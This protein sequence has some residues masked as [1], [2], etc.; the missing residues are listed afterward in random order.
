[1]NK[2]EYLEKR[3]GLIN[4]AD[5]LI[6][7]G[8]IEEAN[9]KMEEV[10][11]LDNKWEE[12]AKAQANL[13]ALNDEPKHANIQNL[14]VKGVDGQIMDRID[15]NTILANDD[16][17]GSVEYRRAF[18]NHVLKGAAIPDKFLNAD[19]NT[20]TTDIGTVIPTTIME[21][22]VEKL[23]AT[24]M[25]LPLVTRTSYQGGLAIP[26]SDV[27]PVATWV[28]EGAG[29]DKQK[30]TTG[31]IVFAYHKLRCAVSIS[32]ETSVVAL[33]VF[34]TTLINN[35][36][37]AM[38]KALEQAIISGTGSGQ[39]K[40]ILAETAPAGQNID[41]AADADVDYETLINA[42]AALP[43]SYESEAVWCMTKKTFMK[44]IGMTDSN[45]QPI[46]RVS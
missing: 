28:A 42:E 18:M 8:K 39:P 10:K 22:I 17:F 1:M 33:G 23:E 32:L 38:T 44:F 6:N 24:G 34:E 35:I 13:S 16:L 19:E 4:E 7:E 27:K 26:T 37:E 3:Q 30:K 9:A 46:A 5:T 12:I 21:R 36:A 29:S 15:N 14:S 20:K 2:K 31:S 41:I 40:G 45:G 25:I 11:E 43:L